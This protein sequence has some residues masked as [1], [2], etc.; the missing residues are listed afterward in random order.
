MSETLW[1]VGAVL[2]IAALVGSLFWV[3]NVCFNK[4]M[5]D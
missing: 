1:Y 3:I 4:L 5:G 2:V